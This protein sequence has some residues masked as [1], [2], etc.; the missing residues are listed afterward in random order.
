MG[1]M[2]KN[3]TKT[4]VPEHLLRHR[5]DSALSLSKDGFAMTGTVV[6]AAPASH[7]ASKTID[8]KKAV[9]KSSINAWPFTIEDV[10]PI[11]KA[12]LVVELEE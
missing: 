8:R 7:R 10:P 9:E 6:P 5:E 3:S 1:V 12:A 4:P 2:P 11:A